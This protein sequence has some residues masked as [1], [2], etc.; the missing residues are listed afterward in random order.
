MQ[1]KTVA[2]VSNNNSAVS[3]VKEKLEE[4]GYGF[5]LSML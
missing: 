1:D 2:V 5:F 3:N 4:E